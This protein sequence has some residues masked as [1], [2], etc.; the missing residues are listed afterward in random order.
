MKK[1]LLIL[2]LC[3]IAACKKKD[4]STPAP[5]PAPEKDFITLYSKGK[6][7]TYT[8]IVEANY[9]MSFDQLSL[10]MN[11]GSNSSSINIFK[12]DLDKIKAPM[13]LNYSATDSTYTRISVTD[14][15]KGGYEGNTSSLA[16]SP[17]RI[18]K[19]MISSLSQF[20]IGGFFSG[21]VKKFSEADS[22]IIDSARFSVQFSRQK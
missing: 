22:L 20:R 2:L 7:T 15:I 6:A 8:S 21:Y 11:S 10:Q 3:S 16:G 17:G 4:T 5:Q 13:S 9:L 14:S 19:F 18:S 12:V 1:A